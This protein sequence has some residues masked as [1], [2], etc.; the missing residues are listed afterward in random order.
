MNQSKV[1]ILRSL[2]R[3]IQPFTAGDPR[4][5]SAWRKFKNIYNKVPRPGRSGYMNALQ[6][7]VARVLAEESAAQP[8]T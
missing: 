1:H 5:R 6:G 4:N 8:A 7:Q 3:K 2:F